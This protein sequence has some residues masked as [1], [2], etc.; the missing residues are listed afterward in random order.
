LLRRCRLLVCSSVGLPSKVS[1]DATAAQ[2]AVL[3]GER[4]TQTTTV[5]AVI[6]ARLRRQPVLGSKAGSE[7]ASVKASAS[8]EALQQEEDR[9]SSQTSCDPLI[10][11]LHQL[12][13]HNTGAAPG[14]DT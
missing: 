10:D 7:A 14:T 8:R 2:L 3:L 1:L 6:T 12:A 11:N 5:H 9:S 13:D 4:A